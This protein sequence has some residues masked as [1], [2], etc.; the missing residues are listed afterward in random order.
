VLSTKWLD[1][2]ATTMG[3]YEEFM[4]LIFERGVQ[5]TDRT[6]TGTRSWFGY[7]MRFD[8]TQ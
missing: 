5:K 7:Q 2:R 8:V 3:P 4:G 6:R 1:Y